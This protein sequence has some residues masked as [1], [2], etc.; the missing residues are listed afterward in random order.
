MRHLSAKPPRRIALSTRTGERVDC[1]FDTAATFILFDL[2]A[3]APRQGRL[4]GVSGSDEPP[5]QRLRELKLDALAG[6]ELLIMLS[7][8]E[9]SATRAAERRGIRVEHLGAP[10][11]IGALLSD[12]T[13]GS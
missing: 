5:S 6:T 12:L 10:M 8:A 9:T 3:D 2:A 1:C 4:I 7:P 13:H 11:D